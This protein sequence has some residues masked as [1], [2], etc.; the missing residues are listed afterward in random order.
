MRKAFDAMHFLL[1]MH[2]ADNDHDHPDHGKQS[3]RALVHLKSIF[4]DR[5]RAGDKEEEHADSQLCR[6]RLPQPPL[7]YAEALGAF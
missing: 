4:R 6:P 7:R 2:R 1:L 5:G 3:I